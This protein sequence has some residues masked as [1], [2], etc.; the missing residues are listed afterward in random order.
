[1]LEG[2]AKAPI[3]HTQPHRELSHLVIVSCDIPESKTLVKQMPN[4]PSRY[5]NGA[6]DSNHSEGEDQWNPAGKLDSM[7]S[8]VTSEINR[9]KL[10]NIENLVLKLRRLNYNHDEARTYYIASLCE[11]TNPDHRYISEILLASGLLLR[12]LGSSLTTFQLHPSGHPI[13]PELFYVLEQTKASSLL[14]KEECIPDKV[15]LAKQEKEKSHRKLIFDAVNEI[16]VHKL[17]SAGISPV[18]GG[19]SMGSL[20]VLDSNNFKNLM[21]ICLYIVFDLYKQLKQT[22][23]Q[24]YFPIRLFSSITFV[25]LFSLLA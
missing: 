1:M 10:K 8:G 4:A 19:A 16:V 5:S 14:A 15:T 7:E 17:D 18:N 2:L 9:M 23:L 24:P 3:S 22:K 11:N 12:D 13:N 20:V 6:E 25:F 21:Y